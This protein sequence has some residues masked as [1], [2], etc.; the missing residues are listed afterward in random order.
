MSRIEYRMWI[1]VPNVMKFSG[2]LDNLILDIRKGKPF[3]YLAWVCESYMLLVAVINTLFIGNEG[4]GVWHIELL[5][6]L[7]KFCACPG[8]EFLGRPRHMYFWKCH[9]VLCQVLNELKSIVLDYYIVIIFFS[10]LMWI[11]AIAY[12]FC[13][14]IWSCLSSRNYM[15]FLCV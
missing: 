2:R 12:H 15:Q 1:I 13:H 14:Q 9:M 3:F 6:E 7:W 8:S 5:G 4:V 10:C 11:L